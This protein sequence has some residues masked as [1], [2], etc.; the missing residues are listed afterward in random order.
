MAI[1][2]RR[3][4][5]REYLTKKKLDKLV[6]AS[7]TATSHNSPALFGQAFVGSNPYK[8]RYFIYINI[9]IPIDVDIYHYA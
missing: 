4:R 9:V 6:A 7:S 8:F 2:N 3:T 1:S 5:I